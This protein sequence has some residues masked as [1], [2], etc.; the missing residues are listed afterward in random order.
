[1]TDLLGPGD[2]GAA[3]TIT[4]T[5]DVTNPATGDT[6]FQDCTAGVPGTGTSIV[7]KW[8]NR[9]LQQVRRVITNANIPQSNSD[10]DMLGQAIQSGNLNNAGTFGGTANALTATLEPVPAS[11]NPGLVIRGIIA[12]VNTGPATLQVVGVSS[13][14]I[15]IVLQNGNPLVGGEFIIGRSVSFTYDGVYFQVGIPAARMRLSANATFYVNASSGSDTNNGQSSGAAWQTLQHAAN[16]ISQNVDTAGFNVTIS[17]TGAFTAGAIITGAWSGGGTVTFSFASG[18][19]VT[20]ANA[21]CFNISGPGVNVV[22]TTASGTSVVLIASGST[23]LPNGCGVLVSGF[24]QVTVSNVNFGACAYGQMVANSSGRLGVG[25]N[26]TISGGSINALQAA[27]QAAIQFFAG[28]TSLV[29]TGTPAFSGAFAQVFD[30]GLLVISSSVTTITGSATGKRYTAEDT[31]LIDTDASGA[32]YLPGSSA[33]TV[34]NSFNY[35]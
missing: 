13:S 26:I 6:F 34:A 21:S 2:A 27:S 20:V 9:F 31:S 11:L 7:S 24:A 14:N 18:S 35:Q 12:A 32:S 22:I 17:C 19:T 33:G 29:I 4:T 10:D 28:A 1:M 25:A 15:P 23:A 8:L 5:T 30:A 16:Y 3:N